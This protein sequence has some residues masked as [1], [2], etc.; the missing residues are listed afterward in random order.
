M[1][2]D[3]IQGANKP[4]NSSGNISQNWSVFNTGGSYGSLSYDLTRPS[5]PTWDTT[6]GSN[7]NVG[8]YFAGGTLTG[9]TLFVLRRGGAWNGTTSAGVF[10]LISTLLPSNTNNPSFGFRCVLR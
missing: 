10:A 9:T 8:Q 1:T 7:E 3:T 4:N 5:N 2:N 6:T